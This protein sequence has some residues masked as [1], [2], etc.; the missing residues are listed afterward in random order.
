MTFKK[1]LV[2]SGMFMPRPPRFIR[3]S[4]LIKAIYIYLRPPCSYPACGIRSSKHYFC[5]IGCATIR[6]LCVVLVACLAGNYCFIEVFSTFFN[7]F[8]A[9]I[10]LTLF[11]NLKSKTFFMNGKFNFNKF[12]FYYF[13]LFVCECKLQ[14]FTMTG[15]SNF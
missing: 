11:Q 9:H 13:L 12:L 5:F 14:K 8:N 10:H 1:N 4:S 2:M 6:G 15:S 3:D 7:S